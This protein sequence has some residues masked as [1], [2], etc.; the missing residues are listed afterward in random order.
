[1]DPYTG[2]QCAGVS[3]IFVSFRSGTKRSARNSG[4]GNKRA[5]IESGGAFKAP[6]PTRVLK[7][8]REGVGPREVSTS[9]QPRRFH[10]G[11]N[12]V[13]GIW[14]TGLTQMAKRPSY[15]RLFL[16]RE[17]ERDVE[18]DGDAT[19]LSIRDECKYY[20]NVKTRGTEEREK[21]WERKGWRRT[22]RFTTMQ[23]DRAFTS[24]PF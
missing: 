14:P 5:R 23:L 6:W 24:F 21:G 3:V 10:R 8:K 12:A 2:V 18:A 13:G 9:F 15:L 7:K 20:Y 11:C 22:T 16:T 19:R 17:R 4:G 1:M